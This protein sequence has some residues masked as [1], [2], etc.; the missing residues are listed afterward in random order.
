MDL[1]V[2]LPMKIQTDPAHSCFKGDLKPICF[3]SLSLPRYPIYQTPPG[4][5]SYNTMFLDFWFVH[6]ILD[7]VPSNLL[8]WRLS[9]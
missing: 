8:D 3:R 2:Y 4:Y 6:F 7:G 1:F 9:T 5:V